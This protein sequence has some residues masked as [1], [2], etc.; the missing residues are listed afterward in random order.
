LLNTR[1]TAR[2]KRVD[3]PIANLP[4]ALHGFT[5]RPDQRHPCRPHHQAGYV[6][7]IVDRV[8][9]LEPDV[10]AITGDLVDGSVPE[11]R[12]H[13]APLADLRARHGSFFVTG[14]HEYYAGVHAWLAEVRGWASAC[15]TTSTW[16]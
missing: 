15:C 16:C 7:R 11:L 4:P 1:R 14:N 12:A 8:N 6:Q 10:V 9:A 5:H 13:V 3:V 2:V